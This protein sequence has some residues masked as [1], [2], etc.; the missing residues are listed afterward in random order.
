MKEKSQTM[1]LPKNCVITFY[2]G[3]YKNKKNRHI[4][5]TSKE[6]QQMAQASA[7]VD[8]SRRRK[9]DQRKVV[10]AER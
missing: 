8:V 9:A 1:K 7:R 5:D 3:S 10:I 4:T 6:R 2:F